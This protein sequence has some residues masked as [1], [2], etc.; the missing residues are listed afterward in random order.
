M[1][2]ANPQ[3][4]REAITSRPWLVVGCVMETTAALFLLLP[5]LAALPPPKCRWIRFGSACWWW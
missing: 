4:R 5:V 1:R 3:A 2:L